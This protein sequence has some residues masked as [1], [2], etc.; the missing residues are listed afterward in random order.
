MKKEKLEVQ[1]A[2]EI[3]KKDLEENMVLET[4]LTDISLGLNKMP[5][6]LAF[7]QDAIFA[8]RKTEG[9]LIIL[10][11]CNSLAEYIYHSLVLKELINMLNSK[12]KQ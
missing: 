1:K 4:D 7:Y 6:D 3:V 5:F 11:K 12:A 10:K 9:E 8:D 2:W